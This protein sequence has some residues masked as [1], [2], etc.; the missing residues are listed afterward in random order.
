[1]RK[2]L[3][4]ETK[5]LVGG[6]QKYLNSAMDALEEYFGDTS[7]IWEK[8]KLNVKKKLV[9]NFG[10]SWGSYGD[11]KR[12]LARAKAIEFL[13]EAAELAENY[14]ELT[15]EIYHSTTLALMKDLFLFDY[16]EKYND[17]VKEKNIDEKKKLENLIRFLKQI[18]RS[19]IKGVEKMMRT[20]WGRAV[21]SS[22]QLKLH[23]YRLAW[24][25]IT[26]LGSC[27]W[28]CS[29][30]WQFLTTKILLEIV[31]ILAWRLGGG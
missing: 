31:E 9:G 7:K 24:S 15:N 8:C 30:L 19:A 3:T 25:Y 4:G 11:Q 21:L 12:V 6:H 16:I 10:E 26:Y 2:Y 23:S 1:M 22:V 29:L 13:R 28:S 14:P 5:K 17:I 20:S 27:D 18:K